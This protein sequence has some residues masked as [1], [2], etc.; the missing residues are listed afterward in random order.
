MMNAKNKLWHLYIRLECHLCPEFC[1]VVDRRRVI[2]YVLLSAIELLIIPYHFVLFYLMGLWGGNFYNTVHTMAF[3]VLQYL[4]LSRKVVFRDGIAMLYLLSFLKLAVDSFLF[5]HDG[6]SQDNISVIS[7]IFVMFILALTSMS[8]RLQRTALAITIGLL[9]VVAVAVSHTELRMLFFSGKGMAV[10][11]LMILYVWLYNQD[12]VTSE[13][14]RKP[15]QLMEEEKKALEM[16]ANLKAEEKNLA[17]NLM[18]RLSKEQQQNIVN[19][20]AEQLKKREL[21]KIAWD[22]VCE[23]LTNSEKTICRLV[24]AGKTLKEICIELNKSESNITSQRSHIRKKL[25]ME[26][27]DDLK[28]VLETRFYEAREKVVPPIRS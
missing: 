17:E 13:G 23:E 28:R 20:A 27:K 6:N 7:N 21:D 11:F 15:R 12:Y 22:K 2:A 1:G 26:R 24:L 5:L 4:I 19:L 14:L 18:K 10:G 8:Q 9:P 25:N 16:L 3:A